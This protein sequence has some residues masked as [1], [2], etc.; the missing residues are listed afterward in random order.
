MELPRQGISLR[1]TQRAAD[2]D[3]C[4]PGAASNVIESIAVST[5]L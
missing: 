3:L 1:P 4:M 2:A 5:V